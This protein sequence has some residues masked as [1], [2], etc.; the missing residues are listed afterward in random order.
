MPMVRSY[1]LKVDPRDKFWS[2]VDKRGPDEC[3]EW[4][5]SRRTY[6]YGQ[7]MISYKNHATH[8]LAWELANGEIPAGLHVCHRCDNPPCCNPAHLFLGTDADNN[9][10]KARKL[11]HPGQ[12]LCPCAVRAIRRLA[13]EGVSQKSMARRFGVSVC[14]IRNVLFGETWRHVA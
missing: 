9:L 8:R 12:K 11:R 13:G 4:Q 7:F 2:K 6:G 3:W 5:G 10:D 1:R 14:P